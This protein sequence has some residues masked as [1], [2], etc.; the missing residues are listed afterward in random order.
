MTKF[1]RNRAD[2]YVFGFN[3]FAA[4]NPAYEVIEVDAGV[5][6]Q[7]AE[8]LAEADRVEPAKPAKKVKE[9]A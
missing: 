3:A 2:G 4:E 6:P 5:N 7:A 8:F 1:L 9:V